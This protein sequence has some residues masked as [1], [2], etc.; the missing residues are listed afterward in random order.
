[1]KGREFFRK[2]YAEGYTPWSG[3]KRVDTLE[4][5]FINCIRHIRGVMPT[6]NALD[7]GCGE[8]RISRLL[9]RKGFHVLGID[10][11]T[12]PLVKA[13]GSFRGKR[14]RSRGAFIMGDVMQWPFRDGSFDIAVD[15][16]CFHH[17]TQGDW[18]RYVRGLLR[19]MKPEGFF[20]L[21]VFSNKDSHAKGR[22]RRWVYHRGHYDHFFTIKDLREIFGRWFTF[23]SIEGSTDGEL[24][25][26]H[27]LLRRRRIA[28]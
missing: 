23:V 1:M 26:H 5:E 6:G 19:V 12:A 14:Y 16:G 17:V 13:V 3:M 9:A 2:A 10:Y 8:G 20:I 28:T 15:N 4:G 11:V 22:K 7:I 24:T 21:T 18:R 27:L 25:F